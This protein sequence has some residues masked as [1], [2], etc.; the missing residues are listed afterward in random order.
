MVFF[1]P[2]NTFLGVIKLHIK[3][4]IL[5]EMLL[6]NHYIHERG[7]QIADDHDLLPQN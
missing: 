7:C 4:M 5:L 3:N 2:T 1:F 6:S